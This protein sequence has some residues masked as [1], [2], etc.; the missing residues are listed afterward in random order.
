MVFWPADSQC[1]TLLH[2]GP[3]RDD[4]WLVLEEDGNGG[5]EIVCR[6]RICPCK[7]KDPQLCEVWYDED[8]ACRE[9][10]CRVALA[11]EQ[12]G[13][14]EEGEQLLVNPFGMGVC[15]CRS[16]PPHMKWADDGR[17]YELYTQGPC[18]ENHTVQFSL[19]MEELLCVAEI[20]PEGMTLYR[21]GRC[22]SLYTRG[23]CDD[24]SEL[25][26]DPSSKEPVCLPTQNHKVKRIFDLAP[27]NLREERERNSILGNLRVQ[28][29]SRVQEQKKND[30]GS[31][32]SLF[33]QR[34]KKS[35]Y[36]KT[37]KMAIGFLEWLRSYKKVLRY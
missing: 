34:R 17:C 25:V 19:P 13:I 32:S 16:D 24:Y 20:C 21:D 7:G 4:E 12:Q 11:A 3:C 18:P 22:Y 5:V 1:Y 10:K 36:N 2:K 30:R 33:E 8:D 35:R 6:E 27:K 14:C 26:L 31:F 15:G 23:P 29:N 28:M 9:N 37:T